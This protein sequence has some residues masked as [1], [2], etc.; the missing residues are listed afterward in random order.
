MAAPPVD[1]S[2]P[3]PQ[4]NVYTDASVL[5]STEPWRSVGSYGIWHPNRVLASAWPR[6]QHPTVAHTLRLAEEERLNE[7]RATSCNDGVEIASTA[8][9]HVMSPTRL[10]LRVGGNWHHAMLEMSNSI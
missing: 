2:L 7:H 5:H 4:L 10:E 1:D 8:A 6:E 3:P 9:E